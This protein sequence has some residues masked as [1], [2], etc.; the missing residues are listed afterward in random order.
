METGFAEPHMRRYT[1]NDHLSLMKHT[2]FRQ[3]NIRQALNWHINDLKLDVEHTIPPKSNQKRDGIDNLMRRLARINNASEEEDTIQFDVKRLTYQ[4]NASSR[5]ASESRGPKEGGLEKKQRLSPIRCKC[6]VTIWYLTKSHRFSIGQ[7]YV[8]LLRESQQCSLS[9]S[10]AAGHVQATIKL[11][12]VFSFKARELFATIKSSDGFRSMIGGKYKLQISLQPLFLDE[13]ALFQDWPPIPISWRAAQ[14]AKAEDLD[15]VVHLNAKLSDFS[16]TI[17]KPYWLDVEGIKHPGDKKDS[18]DT[19]YTIEVEVL[20]IKSG[21]AVTV[22]GPKPRKMRSTFEISTDQSKVVLVKYNLLDSGAPGSLESQPSVFKGYICPF[23]QGRNMQTVKLLEFHL[24]TNHDHF[25][26]TFSEQDVRPDL[27]SV[28]KV[29]V[30]DVAA[31]N[32]SGVGVDERK[33]DRKRSWTWIKPKHSKFFLGD[34]CRGSSDWIIGQTSTA[35]D[36]ERSPTPQEPTAHDITSATAEPVQSSR[37]NSKRRFPVPRA[38]P[39][40]PFVRTKSKRVL[41]EGELLSESD[42][43][44]DESWLR[45]K[46]VQVI[47]TFPGLSKAEVR[48]IKRWDDFISRVNLVA[49]RYVGEA[50]IRF[51][52]E[53]TVW[54]RETDMS[55]EFFKHSSALLLHGIVAAEV[56]QK[57]ISIIRGLDDLQGYACSTGTPVDAMEEDGSRCGNVTHHDHDMIDTT[58]HVRDSQFPNV[59]MYRADIFYKDELEKS[60]YTKKSARVER[61]RM[62]ALRM[63]LLELCGDGATT[64]LSGLEERPRSEAMHITQQLVWQYDLSKDVLTARLAKYLYKIR[65]PLPRS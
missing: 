46:H 33:L 19:G 39:Q 44:I 47:E 16:L 59:I 53:N 63:T 14:P 41:H 50:L 35:L 28:I 37:N 2:R 27:R 29:L 45:Q 17:S 22:P 1:E 18:L 49:N 34:Y 30:V 64:D 48:F 9:R 23:C 65:S 42:D 43:E 32:D 4:Q 56:V 55:L 60:S 26:F 36:R 21:Q 11:D 61:Q 3:K 15:Y 25:S 10:I 24:I 20:R 12:E 40:G 6:E 62:T 31:G 5:H 7:Q 57:C 51:T 54:L 8:Q 13:S 52:R 38:P 58:P